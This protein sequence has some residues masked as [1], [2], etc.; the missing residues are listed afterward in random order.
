[1]SD[2]RAVAYG[3]RIRAI[4]ARSA[5]AITVERAG[6]GRDRRAL[7]APMN[8]AEAAVYFDANESVGLIKPSLSAW[9]E[10]EDVPGGAGPPLIGDI[11]TRDGRLWT[12]RKVQ[13]FR[14][15]NRALL[16]LALC[17]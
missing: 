16:V 8:N 1:M 17:D 7:L 4:F 13:I 11:F 15:G 2:T 3:R 6:V 14:K 12:V 10:G 9:F 5:E